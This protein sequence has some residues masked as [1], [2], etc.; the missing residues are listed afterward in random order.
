VT[1]SLLV[2][3]L[4]TTAIATPSTRQQPLWEFVQPVKGLERFQDWSRQVWAHTPGQRD[5]AARTIAGWP[6][7]D[8]QA[9]RVYLA[10]MVALLNRHD[11]AG[12]QRYRTSSLSGVMKAAD[13]PAL[14]GLTSDTFTEP[15]LTNFLKRAAM[16]HTDIALFGAASDS[17]PIPRRPAP[18]P[19]PPRV[20]V[21]GKDGGYDA[22]PVHWEI[23]R[24]ALD[25]VQPAPG[26]D[27]VVAAWYRATAAHMEG[28]RQ[29]GYVEPHLARARKI[30]PDD[31]WLQYYS[32]VMHEALASPSVQTAVESML[33]A[34][35]SFH[36]HVESVTKEL[37]QAEAFF[38]RALEL[39]PELAVARLHLGRVVGVLGDHPAAADELQRALPHLTENWERYYAWLFLGEEE[40]ARAQPEEARTAFGHARDLFPR[41]QSPYLALSQLA[42]QRA[43]RDGALDAFR[44]L[45]ALT[46]QLEA[47]DDPWGTYFWSTER[48]MTRLTDELRRLVADDLSR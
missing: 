39:D 46:S 33:R 3:V 42:W 23:G 43:D 15:A 35:P 7:Q 9:Q 10:A 11:A 21:D 29:L 25:G 2:F 26:E 30:F 27:P 44:A 6:P 14:V 17:A 18:G 20:V 32:G 34:A 47:R 4:A 37:R 12:S 40:A 13:V 8:L 41:A 22:R 1:R 36:P 28:S 45:A 31:P 38:R 5:A 16:L 24:A 48:T 19:T